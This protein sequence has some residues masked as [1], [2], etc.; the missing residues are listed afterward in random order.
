MANNLILI[1]RSLLF[2][3]GHYTIIVT[4]SLFGVLLRPLSLTKRL[5]FMR[6]GV[7]LCLFW[8]KITCNIKHRVHNLECIEPDK[9]SILLSRHESTWE[10]LAFHALFPLQINVVKKELKNIPFFGSILKTISSIMIDREQGLKAI[11]Q[12]KIKS[13]EAIKGGF[14]VVIFPGGT[15]IFPRELSQIQSGGAILAKQEKTPVYLVTHNAGTAWPKGT[16]IKNPGHIEV[17]I[18]RL[19]AVDT[20]NIQAI[21]EETHAWFQSQYH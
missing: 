3:I 14:W 8:L 9:P 10:A 21:N 16:F 6:H 20:K 4:F 18:K 13:A 1:I 7:K 12:V 19:E 15:R 11:K 2:Y 17:Y 5:K